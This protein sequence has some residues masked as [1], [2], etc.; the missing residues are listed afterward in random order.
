MNK[1]DIKLIAYDMFLCGK[2]NCTKKNFE[3]YFEVL[4]EE[5]DVKE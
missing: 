1:K 3:E 2:N 5:C 4:Y